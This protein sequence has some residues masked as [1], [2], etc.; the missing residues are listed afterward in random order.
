MFQKLTS[1]STDNFLLKVRFCIQFS[2]V[3]QIASEA[4]D[5][6]SE[7]AVERVCRQKN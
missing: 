2:D 3:L 6:T 7:K 4:L 5:L 1:I